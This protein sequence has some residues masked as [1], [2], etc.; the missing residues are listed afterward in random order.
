MLRFVIMKIIFSGLQKK[1]WRNVFTLN[2]NIWRHVLQECVIE[3]FDTN[4]VHCG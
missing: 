4:T 1:E 3:T 2:C